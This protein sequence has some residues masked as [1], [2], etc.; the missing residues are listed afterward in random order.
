MTIILTHNAYMHY[1][2]SRRTIQQ[3]C[4]SVRRIHTLFLTSQKN[5]GHPQFQIIFFGTCQTLQ[6]LCKK[7]LKINI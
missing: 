4:V 3:F 2:Q 7:C 6:V 5:K 1:I